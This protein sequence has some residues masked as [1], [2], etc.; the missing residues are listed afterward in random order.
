MMINVPKSSLGE[1]IAVWK[2]GEWKAVPKEEYLE[3]FMKRD[4]ERDREF[5]AVKD[6]FEALKGSFTDLLDHYS[7]LLNQNDRFMEEV[8]SK[9]NDLKEA[10]GVICDE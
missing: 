1:F 8:E 7:E 9:L 4:A 10:L 2:D 5:M 3:I 6:S